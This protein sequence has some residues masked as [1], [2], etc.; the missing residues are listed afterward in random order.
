MPIATILLLYLSFVFNS[1]NIPQF[2]PYNTSSDELSIY[3]FKISVD[4]LERIILGL[5]TTC[6]G[7]FLVKYIIQAN[8]SRRER[9]SKLIKA[10]RG[11]Y[12]LIAIVIEAAIYIFLL[13]GKN[14][15]DNPYFKQLRSI[16]YSHEMID[17]VLSRRIPP[18]NSTKDMI[19][20]VNYISDKLLS[21]DPIL[22]KTWPPI[23]QYFKQE[24]KGQMGQEKKEIIVG[25]ISEAINLDNNKRVVAAIDHFSAVTEYILSGKWDHFT[26]NESIKHIDVYLK[27]AIE[28]ARLLNN[29]ADLIQVTFENR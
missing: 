9:R 27:E 7:A 5:M 3:S 25:S 26:P 4:Y 1:H 15:S 21:N 6:F 19:E 10:Y 28:L 14:R 18:H 8:A 13:N 23:F 29:D 24:I 11:V 17:P 20:S 2:I 22:T 16:H 12:S